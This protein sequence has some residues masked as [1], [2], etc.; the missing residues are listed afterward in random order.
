MG[1]C[2]PCSVTPSVLF[3][4]LPQ[5]TRHTVYLPSY[6]RMGGGIWLP[7]G[8]TSHTE[9]TNPPSFILVRHPVSVPFWACYLSTSANRSVKGNFNPNPQEASLLGGKRF[10]I[11]FHHSPNASVD[12][13]ERKPLHFYPHWQT[14]EAYRPSCQSL[15]PSS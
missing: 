7:R 9:N 2:P 6:P 8:L 15:F 10:A 1:D 12:K 4:R 13:V 3:W 11:Y 5:A 14:H